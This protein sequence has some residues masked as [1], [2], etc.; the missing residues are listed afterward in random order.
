MNMSVHVS[1]RYWFYFLWI[2]KSRISG[3][4]HSSIFNFLRSFHTV[5]HNSSINL[6][7]RKQC[8]RIP[9]FHNLANICY[10]LY[11]FLFIIAII[12]G[13]RWYLIM[14]SICISLM[15]IGNEHLFMYLLTICIFSLEN[16]YSGSL[17]IFKIRLFVS[18]LLSCMS[19]LYILDINP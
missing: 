19:F 15:V 9:F 14:L 8:T 5:F 6:H 13:M 11:L 3:S 16:V 12:T 10:F 18:F 7:S 2:C 4:Y 1:S 17:T